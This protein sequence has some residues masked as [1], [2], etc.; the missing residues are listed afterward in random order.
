MKWT[1]FV[2]AF[3]APLIVNGI[4]FFFETFKKKEKLSL[5][6]KTV[7]KE[8]WNLGASF[9]L[10]LISAIVGLFSTDVSA[11]NIFIGNLF[12]CLLAREMTPLIK[13]D[14]KKLDKRPSPQS[15]KPRLLSL[16]SS[17]KSASSKP[18]RFIFFPE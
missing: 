3:V 18:G 16:A 14:W 4:F 7:Q 8:L 10:C 13:L 5:K 6:N 12:I 17:S 1:L 2:F 15:P 11:L 9:V